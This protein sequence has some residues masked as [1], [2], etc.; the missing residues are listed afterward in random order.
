MLSNKPKELEFVYRGINFKGKLNDRQK[1][2]IDIIIDY[3]FVKNITDIKS[4]LN[5]GDDYCSLF[6]NNRS[7]KITFQLIIAF[8]EDYEYDFIIGID[9]IHCFNKL[10]QCQILFCS[11][12]NIKKR[13]YNFYMKLLKNH[14]NF[15]DLDGAFNYLY[16]NYWL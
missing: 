4:N 10:K 6:L 5:I 3:G 8:T 2:I 9:K 7:L 15:K 11:Y 14:S 16:Q 12:K 13:T 1:E